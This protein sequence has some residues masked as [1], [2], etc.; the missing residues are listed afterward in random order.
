MPSYRFF[1]AHPKSYSE[2]EIARLTGAVRAHMQ[3]K[4]PGVEIVLGSGRDD[5][6]AHFN[7][8]GSWDAWAADVA[9]GIF[10]ESREPRY[11]GFVVPEGPLGK[12]TAQILHAALQAGKPVWIWDG[13]SLRIAGEIRQVGT[14]FKNGWVIR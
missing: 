1:I 14:D 8:L 10:F 7:R 3:M 9:V 2:E 13:V 6:A 5:H 11:H 12:A 4:Q